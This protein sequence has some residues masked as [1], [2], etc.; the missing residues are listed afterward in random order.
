MRTRTIKTGVIIGA[1]V[2]LAAAGPATAQQT[3]ISEGHVDALAFSYD[4]TANE[5]EIDVELHETG[6]VL[7]PADV[8]FDVHDGHKVTIPSDISPCVGEEGD[9]VW[10]LPRNEAEGLIWAG[11]STDGVDL[12][13]FGGSIQADLVSAETPEGGWV[14]VYDITTEQLRFHSS[15]FCDLG[16][17]DIT[18]SHHHPSWI[19]NEPGTYELT[20]QVSGDHATDGAVDSDPVTYTFEVGGA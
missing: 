19:F 4:E 8:V 14:S 15:V 9:E 20:F 7:N 17:T 12:A 3:T 11:W 6:Q 13:D 5:L 10:L 16:P 2:A 18:E 1:A